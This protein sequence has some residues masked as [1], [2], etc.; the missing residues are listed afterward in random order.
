MGESSNYDK[1]VGMDVHKDTISIAVA[2]AGRSGARFYGKIANTS[3]ALRRLLNALANA[4]ERLHFCYE[5]GPCGYGTLRQIRE[6]GHDC[7]VVA[8]SMTPRKPGERVKT[9]RRDALTLARLDRAGELTLV[10]APDREHEAVRD[11]SRARGDFKLI[12]KQL[13]QRLGALLLRHDKRFRGRKN[14][15]QAHFRWLETQ[16]FD[17]PA[18]QVAFEEYADAV[19]KAQ[20]RTARV[21]QQLHDQLETWS[22]GPQAIALTA[23]R[24]IDW[25]AAT[26]LLA[27]LGDLTR[28]E[29]P[30]PLMDFV[31]LTSAEHSSG[32][33]RRQ[34]A[35]TKAGNEEAR[36]MLIECA[37]A[38]RFPA[39]RSPLIQRRAEKT[40]PAVQELA[41]KAQLRLC[42]R[43][44]KLRDSGK[45]ANVVVT[46]IARELIGFVWAIV[47]QATR[48]EQ[49]KQILRAA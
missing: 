31:G 40:S 47:I 43:Y 49:E 29:R 10:W 6:S 26:T 36:R 17:A 37:W 30:R 2:S 8:P 41:W 5:A 9:D 1:Y 21:E 33:R 45:H 23:L 11:L 7:D 19:G 38:Y 35:I 46:A 3:E 20:Q 4:D 12:D 39:R 42:G 44:R 13:R 22:L 15:T 27:E 18:A 48:E 25:L 28:F 34:G 24:G 16:R 14:W 32:P